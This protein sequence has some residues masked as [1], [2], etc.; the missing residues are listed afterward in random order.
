MMLIYGFP[1]NIDEW[2]EEL[3]KDYNF[4]LLYKGKRLLQKD[5]LGG[6]DNLED[7]TNHSL[8]SVDSEIGMLR[9]VN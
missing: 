1:K 9:R 2:K 7:I 5:I 6:V 3:M 8:F 4:T